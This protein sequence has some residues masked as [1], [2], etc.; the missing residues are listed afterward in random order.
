[1]EVSQKGI[2]L[3]KRFEGL[4]THAYL[5]PKGILTIGYG[6]TKDVKKEDIITEYE[7]EKLLHSD[8]N[9][10]ASKISYSLN[11]DNVKVN[12][13]Q[14]DALCSFA[15]NLGFGSLIFST[16]W[17]KLKAGDYIGASEEFERWVYIKKTDKNGSVIKIKQKGLETRRKAEK[18]LFLSEL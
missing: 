13:H 3:V 12:Q 2:D 8:L 11:K 14:F 1:M 16:L 7:A 4:V 15:F 6:H 17:K 10:F 9:G 18:E 5:C